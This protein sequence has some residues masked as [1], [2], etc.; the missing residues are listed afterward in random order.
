MKGAYLEIKLAQG[1]FPNTI[2]RS[3]CSNKG[4]YGPK[5]WNTFVSRSDYCLLSNSFV[6]PNKASKVF[7]TN[8]SPSGGLIGPISGKSANVFLC[9]R[10]K[11]IDILAH[12]LTRTPPSAYHILSTR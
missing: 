6:L 9:L 3:C 5:C 12:V 11:L 1:D 10:K 8:L 4:F 2:L 7:H